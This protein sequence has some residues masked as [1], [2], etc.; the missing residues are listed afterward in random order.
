MS[1]GSPVELGGDV[2]ERSARPVGP[3]R[4]ASDTIAPQPGSEVDVLPTR[5]AAA[6]DLRV[7]SRG[8]RGPRARRDLVR[9]QGQERRR[10]H[11]LQG[12]GRRRVRVLV[13][14]NVEPVPTSRSS[15]ATASPALPHTARAPALRCDTWRRAAGR[16]L[17]GPSR[18]LRRAPRTGRRP[19]CGCGLRTGRRVA[20]RWRRAR[21]LGRR[22]VDGRR[23]DSPVDT[24]S[25]PASIAA[26]PTRS[27][28]TSCPS[29]R[30]APSAP[31]TEARTVPWPARN[32]TFG[33]REG[34]STVGEIAP[35][36]SPVGSTTRAGADRDRRSRATPR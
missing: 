7:P 3:R 24:P 17:S 26:R 13:G 10:Q 4:A 34:S 28:S 6:P 15:R 1:A 16:P 27:I 18:S 11:D 14:G 2:R 12:R 29:G 8:R 30:L 32:A 20:R 31:R 36:T 35:R 22:G 9:L 23:V 19:R 5:H 21:D 25:A 33:P